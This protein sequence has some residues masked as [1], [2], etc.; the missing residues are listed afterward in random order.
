MV[1]TNDFI[2]YLMFNIVG[3]Q[4]PLLL[5]NPPLTSFH[6]WMFPRPVEET[7]AKE[8]R[9]PGTLN[10]KKFGP[11]TNKKY[12]DDDVNEMR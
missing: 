5:V 10:L 12:D 6:S 7:L 2:E 3:H 8:M 9:K 11:W 4:V 1:L